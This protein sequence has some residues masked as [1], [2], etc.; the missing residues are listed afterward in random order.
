MWNIFK[1]KPLLSDED[2]LFQMECFKWLL[3]N[4][5]GNAFYNETNLVLPTKEFF[6]G[7]ADTPSEMAE[8]V[9]S[10][11][12]KHAG[13]E[14]WPC[15]LEAQ[16]PDPERRVAP[17]L[18]VQGGEYSP[19]GTFSAESSKKIVIT[20]NPSIVGNSTQLIATFAHEL[21]HYLTGACTEEPPGGWDNWEFATDIAA[22]FMGFGIFQAN[23]AFNFTQ[24]TDVDSQGW[25]SSRSGYLSEG[26]FSFAL[27][28]FI[29]LKNIDPNEV[30]PHLKRNI[31][32]YVKKALLEL[33]EA[34][35][36]KELLNTECAS[37]TH[38][39]GN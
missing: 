12:R 2:F 17:T 14:E 36:Y 4:Y 21:A 20:Y 26:E 3:R 24:Y 35:E 27:A 34:E 22:V 7:S 31:K 30:Y 28:V 19:L 25:S 15:E 23:S 8:M 11:V 1:R 5:G 39:N 16:E 33:E 18:A 38:N 10:H 32:S 37:E 9:F 29:K 6:P 13:M